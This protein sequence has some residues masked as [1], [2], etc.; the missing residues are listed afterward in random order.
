MTA[1][2]VAGAF[3]DVSVVL[4]NYNSRAVI[5]QC[6]EQL[7][8]AREIVIVDNASSDDSV[9]Y[10]EANFP[11]ARVIRNKHNVGFGCGINECVQHITNPYFL[12][13]SPDVTI[14][15]ATVAALRTDLV[16][17]PDAACIVPILKAPRDSLQTWVMGPGEFQQRNETLDA[18]G[19]FCTWFV[20]CAA[21]VFRTD[22]FRAIDG[23]D[24][25][26][27]LYQ[28]DLDLCLRIRRA[29]HSMIIAPHLVAGH[30]NSG[31]APPS[32]Q[33][34][35]RK[36]WNFAW[37]TYYVIH[38]HVSARAARIAALKCIARRGPKAL[39][40]ALIRDKK[41]LLRDFAWTHGALSFLLGRLP[42]RPR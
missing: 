28:E 19:P 25:N 32:R 39:F 23:F 31:S 24:S 40:Y 36:E 16:R 30:I 8:A 27:F 35:W 5:G 9:A 3:D 20:T 26:I 18:G 41:R 7:R 4:V 34:S 6:L 21:I 33:L 37:G 17:Y 13:V 15:A 10:I 29:G 12:I 22:A 1:E 38:K 11:N 42:V 2:I 14:D